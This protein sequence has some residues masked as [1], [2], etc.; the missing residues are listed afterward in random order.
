MKV[1]V[2]ADMFCVVRLYKVILSYICKNKE[3]IIC[4]KS[5]DITRPSEPLTPR[6]GRE[7]DAKNE[8][9]LCDMDALS[10]KDDIVNCFGHCV[11]TP[12][13]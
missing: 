7:N 11:K 5:T 4:K 2:M 12:M 1:Q 13:L 6:I 8:L 9:K 10:T 3:S